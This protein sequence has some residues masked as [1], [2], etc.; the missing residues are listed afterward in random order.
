[1]KNLF[2][3][4]KKANEERREIA[5]VMIAEVA[6]KDGEVF[7]YQSSVPFFKAWSTQFEKATRGRSLGNVREMHQN[8]A[9]GKLTHIDYDDQAKSIAVVAKIV[10]ADAWK[11]CKEG[12][13][14]GFSI[15][16]SYVE[17]WHDGQFT[18]Y[19]AMPAEVSIVDNP[20]VPVALFEYVKQDGSVSM[21]KLVGGVSNLLRRQA[22]DPSASLQ[23]NSAAPP[24]GTP[25]V[26]SMYDV[27]TLATMLNSIKCLQQSCAA[28]AQMEDDPAGAALAD[29]LRLWL[30]DGVEILK[31]MVEEEGSELTG[32]DETDTDS[33]S[34]SE[35]QA[36]SDTS[37][38]SDAGDNTETEATSKLAAASDLHKR[39]AALE[40]R[41][42]QLAAD[43]AELKRDLAKI[44]ASLEKLLAQP[45]PAK[46]SRTAVAISK[47]EDGGTHKLD[48]P[49]PGTIE[50]LKK[51]QAETGRLRAH[52]ADSLFRH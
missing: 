5:G 12:V 30:K 2:F 32:G 38:E 21:V 24:T 50:Y 39:F 29:R 41:N 47:E 46:A 44:H 27:G 49:K 48:D 8:K 28:E 45:A 16:G 43:N 33:D 35:T 10:D 19:T 3:Q 18:R 17:S 23:R 6:D 26:K 20:C 11:L 13:Y 1:M 36:S 22:A 34:R 40:G 25:I 4:F 14:T 37:A 42:R 52:D 9:V 7:D 51:V 31:Q 15:G